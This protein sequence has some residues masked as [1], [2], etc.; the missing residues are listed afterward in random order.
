MVSI[1]CILFMAGL[2][3]S[4]V[5]STLSVLIKLAPL[6]GMLH[7]RWRQHWREIINWKPA[8][9][10]AVFLLWLTI[11][12]F[13]SYAEWHDR[14]KNLL[15]YVSF[16]P[17]VC[18]APVLFTQKKWRVV[19]IRSFLISALCFAMLFWLV[20]TGGAAHLLQPHPAMLKFINRLARI[21]PQEF[22]VML[23]LAVY[24]TVLQIIF[25]L[26]QRAGQKAQPI[27]ALR[28][29]APRALSGRQWFAII[30]YGLIFIL[31]GY[32]LSEVQTERIGL[33]VCC[34]LLLAIPFQV[35]HVKLAAKCSVLLLFIVGL[36]LLLPGNSEKVA[37]TY[38]GI[39]SYKQSGTLTSSGVRLRGYHRAWLLWQHHRMA[40]YGTGS[41]TFSGSGFLGG[42]GHVENDYLGLLLQQG[43]VG[44]FLWLLVLLSFWQHIRHL[45][46]FE[47]AVAR[48]VLLGVMI[49]ANTYPAFLVNNT[50]AWLVALL[51]V[52][53]GASLSGADSIHPNA[54][55][56]PSHDVV[57]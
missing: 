6:A 55:Q 39:M 42:I 24:L 56:Q 54:K 3:F 49:A 20:R 35:C 47:K 5:S 14:L 8:A 18:L 32:V 31:L 11:N 50:M 45:P 16:L 38:H 27:T 46:L 1:L 25:I 52:C 9:F 30:C 41:F 34:L 21:N 2:V 43:L 40:G 37:R 23:G 12:M 51:G 19:A 48:G 10:I 22:S 4:P 53:F 29:M 36:L 13:S 17:V 57:G 7:T 44:L 33:V 28:D 15:H 26:I